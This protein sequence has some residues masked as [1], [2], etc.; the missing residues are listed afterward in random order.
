MRTFANPVYGSGYAQ[1]FEGESVLGEDAES[2]LALELA[3]LNSGDSMG[4]VMVKF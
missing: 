2:K 3:E 4:Y 1:G